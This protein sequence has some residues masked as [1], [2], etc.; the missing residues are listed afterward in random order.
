[1]LYATLRILQ[2]MLR[3]DWR[4]F[5]TETWTQHQFEL[6]CRYIHSVIFISCSQFSSDTLHFCYW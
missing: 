3:M 4:Q 2:K 5:R 6:D 1:M